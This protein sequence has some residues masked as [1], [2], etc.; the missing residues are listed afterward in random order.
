MWMSNL[1]TIVSKNNEQLLMDFYRKRERISLKDI[2]FNCKLCGI[3]LIL[4]LL[5]MRDIISN[6]N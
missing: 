3:Y 4:R 6:I 5:H 1:H 2:N